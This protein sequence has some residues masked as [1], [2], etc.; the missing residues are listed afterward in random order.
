MLALSSIFLIPFLPCPYFLWALCLFLILHLQ[1]KEIQPIS[2]T[3]HKLAVSQIPVLVAELTEGGDGARLHCMI[4]LY[5]AL[6]GKLCQCSYLIIL[7][8]L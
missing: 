6:Q 3:G 4:T 8:V 7:S 2:L 5:V 1:T